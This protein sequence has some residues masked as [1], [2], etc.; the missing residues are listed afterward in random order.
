MRLKIQAPLVLTLLLIAPGGAKA[1]APSCTNTQTSLVS[2]STGGTVGNNNSSVQDISQD[3]RYV[4]FRSAATD[5]VSY[6]VN[7]P[8]G[9]N[10]YLRDRSNGSVQV[11]DD[12]PPGQGF[13]STAE[14]FALSGDGHVIAFDT[15]ATNVVPGAVGTN[16]RT[17]VYL[18][19]FR[20]NTFLRATAPDS[21][22]IGPTQSIYDASPFSVSQDSRYVAFVSSGLVFS[23]EYYFYPEPQNAFKLHIYVRD[24]I[25]NRTYLVT[26]GVDSQGHP[27][28][29]DGHVGRPILSA[30]GQLLAFTTDS[31]N[32]RGFPNPSGRRDLYVASFNGTSW[33]VTEHIAAGASGIDTARQDDLSISPD[34]R[35]VAYVAA[36]ANA[37][38]ELYVYDRQ[39]GTTTRP[40][41]GGAR[42]AQTTASGPR[43]GTDTIAW[44][45][46]DIT[47]EGYSGAFWVHIPTAVLQRVGRETDGTPAGRGSGGYPG[48][49][50]G[51]AL[52]ADGRWATY[53]SSSPR[54]T[55]PDGNNNFDVFVQRMTAVAD[56]AFTC[57]SL[58]CSFDATPTLSACT[59]TS[60]AWTFGDSS[61]GSGATPSHTYASP[62]QQPV[63]LT[64]TDVNGVQ[65]STTKLVTTVAD[66]GT[67]AASYVAL[68]PC[69]LWD[70]RTPPNTRIS[71]GHELVLNV[72]N[73]AQGCSPNT[74]P[75]ARAVSINVTAVTPDGSGYLSA[76]ATGNPTLTS[77]LNF[78]PATSPRGNNMIVP[79]AADG[80]IALKSVLTGA[81]DLV[82]DMNGYFT[83]AP[84]VAVTPLGF[85]SL[86]PCRVYDS[87][88]NGGAP[89]TPSNE[90][91]NITMQG[92]CTIPTGAVA[93]SFNAA[94][95][96][97]TANGYL[98]F[99]AAGSPTPVV[100]NLNYPP[101]PSGATDNGARVTL[102]S[103]TPDLGT[104]MAVSSGTAHLVID[105][106]GYFKSDA[107]QLYTPIAPCRALDTRVAA[108]G[109]ALQHGDIRGVQIRGNCG[110]PSDA[111]AAM[112]NVTVVGPNGSG[113]LTAFPSGI[114]GPP[115]AAT[116]NFPAGE[117]AEG[118]GSIVPLGQS[119]AND[120]SV[121]AYLP[122]AGSSTNLV[123]DVFGY[124]R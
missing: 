93:V 59:V 49:A 50:G 5:I 120:L 6:P 74:N 119:L 61:S 118:N 66:T 111:K 76:Y 12:H 70:T 16:G 78:A 2:V 63:T 47:G 51:V 102:A 99:F 67:L 89:Y 52:S 37:T 43:L 121:Y 109:P 32:L 55:P 57:T 68:A 65:S 24:T 101:Q 17:N 88:A 71:S 58:T 77:A 7:A 35:Y 15:Q 86:T 64:V 31:T 34:G 4:A 41:P 97:A 123:I 110:V 84:G 122:P 1:D 82:V 20:T 116:I 56:F 18:K 19:N 14:T 40:R 53:H 8:L 54:I 106:N 92:V 73:P 114:A 81:V 28:A 83:D 23:P 79:V 29:L 72:V 27:T 115:V 69:R 104:K 85:Q 45:D 80:T 22:L 100:S 46:Y 10:I 95:V 26:H 30:N 94:V 96:A 98:T 75:N 108:Q 117:P 42:P 105:A 112:I 90:S 60:Y 9:T 48:E 103:T 25:A 91:R 62:G 44:L 107:P 39:S 87:R 3:G 113:Y 36:E 11:L 33:D 13:N 124:F 21:S 38:G